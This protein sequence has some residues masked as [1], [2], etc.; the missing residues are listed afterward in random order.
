MIHRPYLIYRER[1][2]TEADTPSEI[3]RARAREAKQQRGRAAS[4]VA[5]IGS[6]WQNRGRECS[7]LRRN[8]ARPRVFW[9]P[10]Y[11]ELADVKIVASP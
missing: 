1:C 2:A 8:A 10:T 11:V 5:T 6:P 4:V 7:S 9:R 3:Q